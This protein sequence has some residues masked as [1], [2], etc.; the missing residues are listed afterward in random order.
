[1]TNN[2]ITP[3]TVQNIVRWTS[4][5]RDG[6]K[7]VRTAIPNAS[8]WALW[9]GGEAN[10]QAIR[11]LGIRVRPDANNDWTLTW[12]TDAPAPT[13]REFIMPA[14]KPGCSWSDE[15]KGIFTWFATGCLPNGK[16]SK[17]LVVRAR[18]G[19]GKTTTIKVAFSVAPEDYA[20]YC[21]FNKKNQREAK[22]AI[23]DPRIDI[24]TLHSLGLKF[25]QMVWPGVKPDDKVEFERIDRVVGKDTAKEIKSQ[26]FKLVGFAKNTLIVPTMKDLIELAEERDI[27]CEKFEAEENGGWDRVKLSHHAMLV[28]EASRERDPQGRI[29]FN[30]MVWLP[31]RQGWVRATYGLVVVDECQDMNMPQLMMAIAACKADGRICVGG[32]DRQAIYHFRGATSD[33]IDMMKQRLSADELGLTITYRCPKKVV[34]LASALVPDY[35]AADTAPEGIVE[36]AM[37][38]IIPATVK[39]GDAIIS[40]A[41]APLMPLCL[42]LLRKGT[43][44]RIEGRDVGKALLDIV[45]DLNARSVPQFITKV[46]VWRERQIH[47]FENT[48]KLEEKAAQINDQADTLIAIAEGAS[49]V[50]EIEERLRRLFQ[51]SDDKGVTPAVVLTTVHKAKGLEWEKVFMLRDTFN[52]KRPASAP[53]LSPEAEAARAREESNIYYVALT[54]AKAHLVLAT[55]RR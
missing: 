31:V 43:P 11:N 39:I 24:L 7:M 54:R 48:P 18:A 21:V 20:L 47:R 51:N 53:P 32:D 29:S 33:G 3:E 2:S 6:S 49:S 17:N 45:D 14:A 41:N 34:A 10:K 23:F 1:M 46:E 4:A 42:N 37:T 44:A 15:Q 19:T 28:L 22:E 13:R 26:L 50:G 30:D 52:K 9:R 40:R 25:I 35:R 36:Q 55:E 8:F 5:I 16:L 38:D 27:Q 12:V